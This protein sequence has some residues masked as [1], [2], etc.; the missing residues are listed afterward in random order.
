MDA[1]LERS[2]RQRAG[3]RCEYCRL[4]QAGS[5]VPFEIDHIIARKHRGRTAADNLAVSCIYWNGQILCL[6]LLEESILNRKRNRPSAKPGGGR[7]GHA[8][9]RGSL[10]DP[11]TEHAGDLLGMESSLPT[12]LLSHSSRLSIQT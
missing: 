3:G 9:V 10:F 5:R 8:V 11:A 12:L 4:P 1:G 6:H 2:V 7:T